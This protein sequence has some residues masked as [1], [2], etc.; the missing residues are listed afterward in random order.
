QPDLE[1]VHAGHVVHEDADLA[2]VVGHRRL[3]LRVA[4]AFRERD[5]GGGSLFQ[6]R[7]EGFRPTAHGWGRFFGYGELW[8]RLHGRLPSGMGALVVLPTRDKMPA[9]S[10]WLLAG[11]REILAVRPERV[12]EGATMI[13]FDA[14]A[15]H[16]ALDAQRVARGLSWKD[17][18]AE[19]GVSV[20]TLMR[21]R[22]GGR[23]EVDGTLAMVAWLGRSVE[24]FARDSP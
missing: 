2:A 19:T 22:L 12:R 23:M 3:P 21:T 18:A 24:S 7:C 17:V 8:T 20:S 5:Q 13:R 6:H 1:R 10:R 4:E 15:L 9:A 11:R 14:K 16:R